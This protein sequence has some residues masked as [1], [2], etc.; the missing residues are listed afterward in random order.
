[1]L[2]AAAPG[3]SEVGARIPVDLSSVNHFPKDDSVKPWEAYILRGPSHQGP[4]T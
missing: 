4:T 3:P 2:A 1:M